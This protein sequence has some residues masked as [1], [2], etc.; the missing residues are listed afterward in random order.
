MNRTPMITRRSADETG[1]TLLEII[2]AVFILAMAIVPMLSAFSPAIFTS[3]VQQ[4]ET[5]VFINQARGTLSRVEALDFTTLDA[6]QGDP[7]NLAILFGSQAEA[8]KESFTFA[9][10]TYAPAVAIADAGG[11]VP[12]LLELTVTVDYVSLSTMKAEY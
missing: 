1:F 10:Q 2:L 4:E 5:A 7:V 3:G 12:G 9:G 6:N 8:D 11:G